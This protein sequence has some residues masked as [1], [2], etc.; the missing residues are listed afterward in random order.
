[1]DLS[2]NA[3]MSWQIVKHTYRRFGLRTTIRKAMLHVFRSEP[4]DQLDIKWGTQTR[5]NIGFAD[6][7][8]TPEQIEV[9]R[10]YSASPSKFVC[11][12][13]NYLDFNYPEFSY[14]ELG[15]DLGRTLML[16]YLNPFKKVEG[17]EIS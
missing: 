16:T 8:F 4:A 11:N 17:V 7:G 15:S 13:L 9:G 5:S 3:S 10:A 1:M 12:I 6:L 14:V 2:P